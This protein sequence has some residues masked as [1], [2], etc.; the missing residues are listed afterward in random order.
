M[1]GLAKAGKHASHGDGGAVTD[2]V[3][4]QTGPVFTDPSGKRHR[5]LRRAGLTAAAVLV[6]CL[7]AVVVAM[8]G[9]PQAPFTQWAVAQQQ[10]TPAPGHPSA[11]TAR[12]GL[13][14]GVRGGPSRNSPGAVA[15]SAGGRASS[16]PRA[17]SSPSPAPLPSASASPSTSTTAVPLNPAGKTP[18]GQA[19]SPNPHKPSSAS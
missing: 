13:G 14:P 9:G 15:A 19:K 1:Y 8:S 5:V 10:T 2:F 4:A 12:G 6:T 16:S 7:G 3:A 17:A 11:Q 18:P